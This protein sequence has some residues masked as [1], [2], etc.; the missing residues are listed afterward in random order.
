MR[1]VIVTCGKKKIWDNN[2]M[3]GSVPAREA[4][5]SDYFKNNRQYAE[6]IS[7]EWLIYSTKFGFISP[8]KTIDE[9]YEVEP[10]SPDEVDVETLQR[11]IGD[12]NLERFDQVE[13][14]CGHGIALRIKEAFRKEGL[15]NVNITEPLI[16]LDF[17]RR[18]EKVDRAIEKGISLTEL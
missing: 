1:L 18:M 7:Y 4:F 14:L 10:G 11:Q 12:M 13:V 3:A 6:I 15:K 16:G 8:D 5:V 17:E 2:R 9:N